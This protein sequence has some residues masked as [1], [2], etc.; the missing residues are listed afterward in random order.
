MILTSYCDYSDFYPG[1]KEPLARIYV[2]FRVQGIDVRLVGLLDTG[3]HFCILSSA[4]ASQIGAVLN[5]GEEETRLLTAQ[6]LISGKLY[7]HTIELLAEEG[8]NLELEATIFVSP[9]WQRPSILGYT[10][11]LDRMRFAVDPWE[12]RF[13]F[14]P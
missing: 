14:G 5:D 2:P 12:N 6:G 10:G 4:V 8:D 1:Q 13:Y 11:F 3:G 9:D 7:R